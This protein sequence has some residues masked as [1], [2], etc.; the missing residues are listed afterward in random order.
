MLRRFL[1]WLSSALVEDDPRP[2]PSVAWLF[3]DDTPAFTIEQVEA[4][5]Y[6]QAMLP[7]YDRDPYL[8]SFLLD[9]RGILGAEPDGSA[10]LRPLRPAVPVNPGGTS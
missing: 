7:R 9:M 5:L 1:R 10:V 3:D 6:A 2:A 4:D 8:I